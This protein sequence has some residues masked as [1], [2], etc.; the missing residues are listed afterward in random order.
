MFGSA[1]MSIA[2][3][4][5][6]MHDA[7]QAMEAAEQTPHTAAPGEKRSVSASEPRGVQDPNRRRMINAVIRQLLRH[8][9]EFRKFGPKDSSASSPFMSDFVFAVEDEPHRAD[10]IFGQVRWGGQFIYL[11]F[12]RAKVEALPA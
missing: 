2:Q 7:I 11:S 1:R 6:V 8:D 12:D 9:D 5:S 3:T 10:D 4:R